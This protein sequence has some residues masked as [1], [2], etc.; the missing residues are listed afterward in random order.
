MM[1]KPGDLTEAIT[2]QVTYIR[3]LLWVGSLMKVNT[4]ALTKVTGN[5]VTSVQLLTCVDSWMSV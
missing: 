5:F 1:V 4:K 2:T 3:Y